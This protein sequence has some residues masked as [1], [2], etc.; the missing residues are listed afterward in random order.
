MH[1]WERILSKAYLGG[2]LGEKILII[3]KFLGKYFWENIS[4]KISLG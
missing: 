2:V 1:F 4:Q 3:R